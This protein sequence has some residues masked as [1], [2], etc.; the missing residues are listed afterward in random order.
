MESSDWANAEFYG[1]NL[2]D[3]RLNERLV[4]ITS[5]FISSTQSPINQACGDWAETKAA[6]RF[7]QN[8]NID[9]KDI[10]AH[11][12]QI[13]KNRFNKGYFYI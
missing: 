3:K 6:Y 13:T 9:Y 7:F 8:D 2:G 10:V 1:I 5:Q 11:H 12:A 4:K